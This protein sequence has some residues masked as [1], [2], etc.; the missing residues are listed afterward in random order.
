MEFK[1]LCKTISEGSKGLQID[2]SHRLVGVDAKIGQS[3]YR[4]EGKGRNVWIPRSQRVL[5][6]KCSCQ[7]IEEKA[8]IQSKF[9]S[10]G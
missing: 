3:K 2:S 7:I 8:R 4:Y 6:F 10:I 9:I 5:D 1:P